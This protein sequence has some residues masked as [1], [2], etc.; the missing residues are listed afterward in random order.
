M[1]SAVPQHSAAFRFRRVMN[2]FPLGL[3]YAFLYMGR[4]NLTVAKNA[5]GDLMT[6]ADFGEIFSIGAV[7]Y[8]IAFVINGPLTDRV[9]GRKSMLIGVF[10]ALV[11]NFSMG[12][13][14]Y[15][16]SQLGWNLPIVGTLMVLFAGNMYFQS[17]GAVAIV[18]T[19]APWFHVGERGTF[20]TIFGVMISMGVYFAFDWGAAI[21]QATRAT[22]G[23]LGYVASFVRWIL[24]SSELAR[25][26]DLNWWL[27][28][29]PSIALAA[30]WLIL[31][32][33]LRNTPKEAGFEDFDTGE[34]SMSDNGERLPAS[35]I[36][37]RILKHP[38]LMV[39]CG[40]AV[41]NGVLKNGV[42][43]W[44][45]I[46]AKEVG[47]KIFITENWGLVMLIAGVGGSLLTGWT[48]DKL[49]GSRRAPM[50]AILYGGM[51]AATVIMYFSM[52]ANPWIMG[53]C[54]IYLSASFIGI[55]GILSGTSTIDFGGR[56]N[57]GAAVGIIDGLVYLGTG[58]QN[59]AAG[60]MSPTGADAKDPSRWS[61]WPA[62]LIP[63]AMIGFVLAIRIWSALP[64]GKI[65][66]P[67]APE[68][69]ALP[70][71]HSD[72]STSPSPVLPASAHQV[73]PRA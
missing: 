31:Y 62:L 15:G 63:F 6:K 66:K 69:L 65:T 40:I 25:G 12:L 50:T 48:S 3:A 52:T 53:A 56:K 24:P 4:Y 46:Y 55:H 37:L 18:S 8:G 27:F 58:F 47:L 42:M 14:I 21:V 36:F 51:I 30:M 13:A 26:T 67:S 64:K 59:L 57:A 44:Y 29:I 54:V 39:V 22:V 33:F 49:F 34:E 16:V 68:A 45:P 5:L 11:M 9:G 32:R 23:E 61:S 73:P 1:I 19:K 2:W 41:A 60:Y 17:F 10:G 7:V 28:F 38:V 35:K 70:S 43:N 20:S 71:A 72:E